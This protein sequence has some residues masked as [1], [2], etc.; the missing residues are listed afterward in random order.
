MKPVRM[1]P[2]GQSHET[3]QHGRS[4]D[5][6]LWAVRWYGSTQILPLEQQVGTLSDLG[7]DLTSN[8]VKSSDQVICIFLKGAGTQTHPNFF[9]LQPTYKPYTL[10]IVHGV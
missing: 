10:V 5:G 9:L 1:Q 3:S 6:L 8:N 4:S 7:P 2:A